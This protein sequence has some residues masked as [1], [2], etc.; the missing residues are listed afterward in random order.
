MD[1]RRGLNFDDDARVALARALAEAS[2][3]GHEWIGTEH[4]LLGV[5]GIRTGGAAAVLREAGVERAAL[6]ERAIELA[7]PARKERPTD[8]G[9]PY[10][11]RS[12][13]ILE[14][15]ISEAQMSGA[16]GVDTEHLLLG[17]LAEERGVGATV[18]SEVGLTL[19][20]VRA[21]VHRLPGYE[22][23]PVPARPESPERGQTPR[24]ARAGSQIA[25]IR[26]ELRYRDGTVDQ[27]QF[28]GLAELDAFLESL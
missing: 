25:D 3:L 12:K 11:S 20:S 7:V 24:P 21:A 19:E 13:K 1:M 28:A 5:L 9:L 16:R 8:P 6:R 15:A 22:P 17:I 26:L 2:R 23:G 27:R 14:L 10:T 18:L 4:L